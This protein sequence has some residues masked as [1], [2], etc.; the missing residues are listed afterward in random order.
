MTGWRGDYPLLVSTWD[1]PVFASPSV[2]IWVPR[3][4]RGDVVV[5]GIF[6]QALAGPRFEFCG[7]TPNGLIGG[8]DYYVVLRF[9]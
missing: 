9:P 8:S 6:D 4:D 5:E 3:A 7:A 1:S 2:Q